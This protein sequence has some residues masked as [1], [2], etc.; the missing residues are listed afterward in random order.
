MNK[1][2]YCGFLLLLSLVSCTSTRN[3]RGTRFYHSINTRYNIHFNGSEAYKEALSA[4]NKNHKDD[5]SDFIFLY[6]SNALPKNKETAGGAFDR[7]IE[8]S[9]KA[10]KQ[11]SIKTKPKPKPGKSND[12]KY[13]Q[14][15]SLEEYNP[16]LYK[17]WL[18]MGKAQ[19]H[20]GDFLVASST[21][22]YIA[23]HYASD[24]PKISCE[25]KIWQARCYSEME[26][27]YEAEDILRK[28][29]NESLPPSLGNLLSGVYADYLIKT[30][31][32]KDAVP[33]LITTIRAEKDGTQKNR[34]KYLL[35]QI[36]ASLED[37]AAAY[38]I[39]GE[40][41]G[42]SA[43]Y[44]LTFSAQIRQTENYTGENLKKIT[45]KLKRMAKSSKNADYLDQVYYALG[46]LYM[47]IPDTV[48]AIDSYRNG[49]EKSVQN[50]MDKALCQIR[51][52]D[53]Y[54]HQKQYVEAQPCYSE[55]L[56]IIKKE[57]KDYERVA[58]RSE[59]LDALVIHVEAV[60]LQDSLQTLAA[61][62][63]EEQMAAIQKI[64]EQVI[65]AEKEEAEKAA[66]E[67]YLA[68]KDELEAD[69]NASFD[70]RRPQTSQ[71]LPTNVPGESSFYFYNQQAVAQGKVNF[72]R[73]W[74]RR[75]LEDN[76]R[77]RNKVSFGFDESGG[78]PEES[79][80]EADLPPQPE[81]A[82][83][84]S[85]SSQADGA[86]P[87]TS[88][89]SVSDNKDPK[90]YL[91]QL[92]LTPEDV[93]ASNV[94]IRD[95]LFNIGL[96]YKDM[97]EDYSLSI[98]TFDR[99]NTRFPE[100]EFKLQAYYH[101]YLIYLKL[102]DREM[103]EAC[104]ARIRDEFP[105]SDYAI[106]MA[107]PNYEYNIRMMDVVQD[108]IYE[109]TYRY[110]LD[111]E[112][113]SVRENYRL[114]QARYTQTRLMPKFMFLNALSFVQSN[115]PDTFK[116][117]LRELVEKYPDAD[118][119]VLAGDILKGILSGRRLS[120]DTSPMKGLIFNLRFGAG[121]DDFVA[122]TTLRFSQELNTAHTLMLI[123]PAGIINENLLLFTVAGYNFGNF[124]VKEFDL[125]FEHFGQ[126]GMLQ[127]QGFSNYGE[128]SQYYRMIHDTDGYA[129]GLDPRI[130]IMPVSVDNYNIL[131]KG[132]SLDEYTGFFE[133]HFGRDNTA[134][135]EKWKI[136][137]EAEIR[138]AEQAAKDTA[139]VAVPAVEEAAPVIA[140]E[141]AAVDSL[142]TDSIP[143]IPA[144]AQTP[145][146]ADSTAADTLQLQPLLTEEDME[147]K[148]DEA[149][150]AIT[151]SMDK[152]N[153]SI[154][155]F[156][157]DP[158][159]GF[160]NLFKKKGKKNAIDEYV[161]QQEKEE[162]ARQKALREKQNAEIKARNERILQQQKEQKALLKKQQ[163]EEDAKLKAAREAEKEKERLEKAAIKQKD[164]E[165][166]RLAK[167]KD[168]ARKKK[169]E[170][171]ERL[172]K[173]REK[174][175]KAKEKARKEAQKAKNKNK[176]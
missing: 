60:H 13:R 53:I 51:L 142:H 58:K 33:Y 114:V 106:A 92:P 149:T 176:K 121:G 66:R 169:A 141:K 112:P 103:A 119:S 150:Q 156:A 79:P 130:I 135:I 63:E 1:I 43:P 7:T 94:I 97:L 143:S 137:Q 104:K 70:T 160:M 72:Q 129:A 10:I 55:A 41:A 136:R 73:K 32:G 76:W 61:L 68:K 8:K 111:S 167:E 172:R 36:Y 87:E 100:N 30:K 153:K 173:Q 56:G 133:E 90:F 74:G 102:G 170:D 71:L 54:F 123:Y 48:Q 57:Y 20:N 128:I 168:Q 17:S 120:S 52:G 37:R 132:K 84:D 162:K 29:N 25:A 2:H 95:G 148:V 110:Y 85:V 39:F 19:F 46:N 62:P 11:H 139:K 158:V 115:Q 82:L 6:P 126:I 49:V 98:E 101:L 80:L 117:R 12:P 152:L 34:M 124:M 88:E 174:E 91:Q 67:E 40:V 14:F 35:G 28:V 59:V 122:D 157:S 159:R 75:K 116:V 24:N 89:E 16:F 81:E 83:P 165:K 99:L 140:E 27:F 64:I 131:M 22:S 15:M 31:A 5:Y 108:S 164:D 21:F 118:V 175:R 3:T 146:P 69:A 26:W 144:I 155:D 78:Q 171:A 50:G 38:K 134:M 138:E 9:T 18:I 109:Q 44:P 166:K 96:I 127:I 45:G 42:S 125:A 86:K 147:R 163:E 107:D 113:D 161:E 154:S 77:R 4:Q 65:K 151:E 47:S 145:T 23:R 93:E 105:E